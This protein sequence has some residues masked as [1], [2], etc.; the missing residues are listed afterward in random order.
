MIKGMTGYGHAQFLKGDVRGVI[1]IK[2]LNHRYF[3]LAFHFPPGFAAFENKIQKL[4]EKNVKRGRVTISIRI[5]QKPQPKVS[6]NTE[7]VQKYFHYTNV[8]KKQFGLKDS[9]TLSD[10]I[11]LPGV[12]EAQEKALDVNDLWSTI[13]KYINITLVSLD[14]MRIGE[15]KSLAKDISGQLARMLVRV[16]AIETRTKNILKAKKKIFTHD[17]FTS[18]QKGSDVNEEITR[19]IHYID[20]IKSLIKITNPAGKHLDFIAQEMQREANTIGSKLQ[21]G[22]ISNEVIAI[23]GKIEKIREQ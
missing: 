8:L 16:R 14:K 20:E 5:I 6:L 7:V 4:I 22:I 2:T 1:E 10:L 19:L 21:D 18:F 12:F 17:E 11:A 9:L 23:K 15:G 13:E 3:D